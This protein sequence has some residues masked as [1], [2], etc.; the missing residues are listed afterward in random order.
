MPAQVESL[1]API[2]GF[3]LTL[4]IFSYLLGD[5][6]VYRFA[7][8][9]LAGMSLT[10]ALVVVIANVL[11]PRVVVPIADA[12]SKSMNGQ[13][14]DLGPGL[15]AVVPLVLGMFILLKLSRR[16]APMGNWGMAVLIG[17]GAGLAVGGALV[18]SLF[19]LASASATV[20][21][22]EAGYAILA[23]LATL[24]VLAYFWYTGAAESA[25][26]GDRR[27]LPVRLAALVGRAFLMITFGAL[28]G[29]ALVTGIATLVDRLG[30]LVQIAQAFK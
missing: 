1:F 25:M 22:P 15:S 23:L 29:G 20:N 14:A 21:V 17:V 28:F 24:T 2:V 9:F 13:A 30:L 5:N 11:I 12:M 8:M 10:Y 19:G 3:L 16:L 26:Q 27:G 6:P 18:G 4:V 7:V